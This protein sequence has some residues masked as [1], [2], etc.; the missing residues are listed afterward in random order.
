MIGL[1][2]KSYTSFYSLFISN[3]LSIV[4]LFYPNALPLSW[5]MLSVIPMPSGLKS[6]QQEAPNAIS[7][8]LRGL[9]LQHTLTFPDDFSAI[10][11][12]L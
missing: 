8:L 4:N 1:A 5:D 10:I 7:F 12:I 11:S 2:A 9:T 6:R 3:T